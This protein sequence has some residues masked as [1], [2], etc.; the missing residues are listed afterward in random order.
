ME[1]ES[2]RLDNHVEHVE[3][4]E[5]RGVGGARGEAESGRLDNHVDQVEHVEVICGLLDLIHQS[6]TVDLIKRF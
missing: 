6:C 3:Q 2:G 4:V 1:L 5:G